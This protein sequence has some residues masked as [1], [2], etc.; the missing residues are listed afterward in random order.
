MTR[1]QIDYASY[2]ETARHNRKDEKE[3]RKHNRRSERN[4]AAVTAESVRHNKI[5]ELQANQTILETN[6]HNVA[7]EALTNESI[8]SQAETSRYVADRNA[9]AAMY[10][11]NTSA[12]ASRYNTTVSADVNRAVALYNKEAEKYK[13]D[14]TNAANTIIAQ[15][16][17]ATKI[18]INNTNAQINQ[19]KNNIEKVK[20]NAE[21][22]YKEGKIKLE[23]YEELIRTADTVLDYL[24]WVLGEKKR[25]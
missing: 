20:V 12:S 9:A 15:M 13:T 14:S 25:R 6:R 16:N 5:S 2:L 17:N 3:T 24:K 23:T 4:A 1:N 8:K 19:Q 22:E 7:S 21:K 18:T 11:A 10:S